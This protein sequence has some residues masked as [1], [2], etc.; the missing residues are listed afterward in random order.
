MDWDTAKKIAY[1]DCCSG[2]AGDMFLAALVDA[3]LGEEFVLQLP[4]RLGLAGV[5][6]VVERVKVGGLAAVRL[7]VRDDG[8]HPLRTLAAI[9][10]IVAASDFDGRCRQRIL[11]VCRRLA[12]AEAK[13]HGCRP[14]E[15]HF[16]EIGAVDTL[17]DVA[18]AVAGLAALGIDEVHCGPLPLGRGWI[19]SAHGPLPLPAP[20]VL[21]LLADV[22]VYD[23]GVDMELVTPTGAALI[24]ELAAG[25]GPMPP[26]RLVATGYG[27]GVRSRPDGRPNLL[28]L[29]MGQ[30]RSVAEAQA[31]EILETTIDD[32]APELCGHVTER[33]LAGG[34]LDVAWLPCTMKKSRPGWLLRVV[35]DPATAT[36]LGRIVLAETTAIGL[37]RRRASRWTLPRRQRTVQCRWGEV[38]VKEVETETGIEWRPE[39][40]ECRRLAVRTGVP[41]RR[42]YEEVAALAAMQKKDEESE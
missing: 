12:A 2:V 27:G 8:C 42:I 34:A 9:E 33:L 22:P 35:A 4:S 25:F 19:D 14:E 26:M 24:R 37:C 10:R 11:A 17:V 7:S 3:G 41:L 15:V 39:F 20:A 23:A 6:V 38:T 36:D 29:L 31:V 32:L 18:G 1:L 28:R 21:E 16:H 5:T 30:G 13:V 40:E